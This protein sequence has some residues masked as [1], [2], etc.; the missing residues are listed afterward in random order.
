MSGKQLLTTSLVF[1]LFYI[2]YQ[3]VG[4]KFGLIKQVPIEKPEISEPVGTTDGKKDDTVLPELSQEPLN[5]VDS[6]ETD[7]AAVAEAD[8]PPTDVEEPG[9][10]V[11]E[12][13]PQTVVLRNEVMEVVF[14]NR[15]G[16]I[17]KVTMHGFYE[18]T[19]HLD[20]VVLV[21]PIKDAPGELI[22]D[23][24]GSTS[25]TLYNVDQPD[26]F[27]V[28]FKTVFRGVPIEKT[29]TLGKGYAI[30]FQLNTS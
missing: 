28:V 8:V 4:Y 6:N 3:Y 5:E 26:E 17:R 7:D 30:G 27:R 10:T 13:E 22:F 9:E 25:N 23:K 12:I 1:I 14:D 16:V 11:P 18:S 29:F 20:K 24:L 21:S 2:T 19:K 15:G